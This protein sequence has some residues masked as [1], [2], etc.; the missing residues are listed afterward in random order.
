[1]FSNNGDVGAADEIA[2]GMPITIP[3]MHGGVS[4]SC[5]LCDPEVPTNGSVAGNFPQRSPQEGSTI[6]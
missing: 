1:M 2:R 6:A 5:A 4:R 3:G